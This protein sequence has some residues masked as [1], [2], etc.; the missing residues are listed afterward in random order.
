MS[1]DQLT[2]PRPDD[3]HLHLRDGPMLAA[4]LP[5]T[6]ARFARA[7]VMPNLK[8]PVTT[9]DAA[10]AYR[11]RILAALPADA[12]FE[13]LMTLYLTDNTTPAE[14]ERARASGFV[15]A[16]KYYPAGATTNSDAGVTDMRRTEDT[17]AAMAEAGL[18]LLV[19]G[20]VTDPDVDVFDRERVF[21]E[22]LLAPLAERLPSLRIVLE[23]VTTADGVRF[24]AEGLSLIHI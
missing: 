22:R 10:R 15:K 4:V 21:I 18:P 13:P 8:P 11:E 9:T 6:A 23:H 12:I 20:E 19:H 7:I 1:A 5:H 3:W 17:L 16:V 2:I 24:V 14:I